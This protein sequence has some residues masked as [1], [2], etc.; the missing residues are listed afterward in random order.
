[1][2]K[3]EVL[4]T[5]DAAELLRV[6]PLTLWKWHKKGLAYP[7][8]IGVGGRLR[9]PVNEVEKLMG[10]DSSNDLPPKNWSNS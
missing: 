8:Q 2:E 1:M 5:K 4:S 10:K 6:S 7:L 3:L 9:W